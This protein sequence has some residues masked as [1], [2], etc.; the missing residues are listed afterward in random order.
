MLRN[1]YIFAIVILQPPEKYVHALSSHESEFAATNSE[2][3]I[4][5]RE[6]LLSSA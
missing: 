5:V 1:K 4:S 3:P 2:T 6:L